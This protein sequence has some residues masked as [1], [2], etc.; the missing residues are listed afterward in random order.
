MLDLTMC[1]RSLWVMSTAVLGACAFRAF[2]ERPLDATASAMAFAERS[3]D[4]PELVAFARATLGPETAFP[5]AAW[6]PELLWLAAFY[7]RSELDVARAELD[8]ARAAM[9]T[10]GA[11]PNPRLVLE[12]E[13]VPGA[14]EPWILSW[15]L[16]LP[17][18]SAGKRD[19]RIERA[20]VHA[21]TLE[22]ALPQEAWLI[23]S[24]VRAAWVELTAARIRA[25]LLQ[26]ERAA[27]EERVE[28][29]NAML[30]AGEVSK[31]E[32]LREQQDLA[33]V[34]VESASADTRVERALAR[35]AAELAIP[36]RQLEDV[37]IAPPAEEALPPAPAAEA[38]SELGLANRLD[39][40][41]KLQEYAEADADL[42]LE[43]ARQY[44]DLT[45][46]PGTSW[47]QGDLKLRLGLALELPLF[48]HNQ[49]PIAEAEA[50]RVSSGARFLALQ[51]S[52]LGAIE[53]ARVAYA[54]A[55]LERESILAGLELARH[56]E[57]RVLSAL[58][59]GTAGR[60]ELLDAR[61]LRLELERALAERNEQAETAIGELEDQVQHPLTGSDALG[62]S[63]AP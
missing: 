31:P 35:L 7:Y 46:A 33:R 45:L 27:H 62:S 20:A 17:L 14:A 2:E 59:L 1:S 3:L 26:Q 9:E 21:R 30:L 28:A 51:D 56:Q 34:T 44:P 19:L 39:L 10:A 55:L 4:S 49:G 32:F 52:V 29:R 13:V 60:L 36:R 37:T 42:R 24:G 11:R 38:A 61:I 15:I 47:D 48:H 16:E 53:S 5:P 63:P 22:L 8:E 18:E 25:G 6:T 12:P 57:E 54:G 58:T 40:Q 50:R 43:V 41:M 23:R